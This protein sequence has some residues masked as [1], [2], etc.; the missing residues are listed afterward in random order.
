MTHGL[1]RQVGTEQRFAVLA[2][3]D[4]LANRR[5][6]R[7]ADFDGRIVARNSQVGSTGPHLWP[8]EDKPAGYHEVRSVEDYPLSLYL[9]GSP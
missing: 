5:R 4:P 8:T 9:A 1:N 6:L 3:S 2:R 7:L